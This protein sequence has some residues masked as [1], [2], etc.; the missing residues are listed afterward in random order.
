MIDTAK[1]DIMI[2]NGTEP[3]VSNTRKAKKS[4]SIPHRRWMNG[5]KNPTT[6]R[7]RNTSRNSM[8]VQSAAAIANV[9]DVI[10][11]LCIPVKFSS[12]MLRPPNASDVSENSYTL[13][14]KI[15]YET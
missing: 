4:P 9:V 12:A 11:K 6:R 13:S 2:A 14:R 15:S 7:T 8:S 5:M 1:A 10:R 3:V